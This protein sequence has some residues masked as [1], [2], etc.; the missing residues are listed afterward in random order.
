MLKQYESVTQKVL[1]GNVLLAALMSGRKYN[2]IR[3][4]GFGFSKQSLLTKSRDWAQLS[5]F[6][7]KTERESSLRN[8]VFKNK[9]D[10]G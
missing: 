8:V 9:Q 7:L 10:D 5:R 6:Y 1:C 4:N 2:A 3:Q